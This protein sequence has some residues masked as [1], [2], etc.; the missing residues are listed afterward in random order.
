MTTSA[1]NI[2]DGTQPELPQD[3]LFLALSFK[4]SW[5]LNSAI[6]APTDTVGATDDAIT[7]EDWRAHRAELEAEGGISLEEIQSRYGLA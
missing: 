3:N 2:S 7:L 1:I 6:A 5:D 4:W